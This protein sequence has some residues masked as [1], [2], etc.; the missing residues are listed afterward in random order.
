MEETAV[1][2]YLANKN[3]HILYSRM[4]SQWNSVCECMQQCITRWRDILVMRTRG[5]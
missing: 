5:E 1:C 2:R 3:K 4:Q